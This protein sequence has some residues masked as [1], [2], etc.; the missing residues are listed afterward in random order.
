MYD[1]MEKFPV[2]FFFLNS[3]TEIQ[4]LFKKTLI[5]LKIRRNMNPASHEA[6]DII[7][8]HFSPKHWAGSLNDTP[9]Q[10]SRL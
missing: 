7:Q 5:L 9:G 2:A 10:P 1:W 6:Y 3:F 8:I 4:L